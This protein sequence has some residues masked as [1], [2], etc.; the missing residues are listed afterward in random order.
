MRSL[1]AWL[2]S[3]LACCLVVVHA[4]SVWGAERNVV[5]LA[6]KSQPASEP[7]IALVIGNADYPQAA[8][9][10]PVNDARALA[11]RLTALRFR[12][13]RLENATQDQMYEAIRAFGDQ[14][15][16]GG[17]GLFYYAGHA[18]QVRG[19]NYLLP[20]RAKIEREDEILYRTVDTGQILDKMENAR[21]PRP[22]RWPNRRRRRRPW[23]PR[24]PCWPRW[25]RC[26]TSMR[27]ARPDAGSM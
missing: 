23:R 12:V 20:A 11:E 13:T 4:T 25:P 5:V 6:A 22:R 15:R 17:V 18:L 26:A 21:N 19:R 14:L 7:R 8:L 2:S 16:G 24:W 10:N 3:F 27:S 1:R 9:A